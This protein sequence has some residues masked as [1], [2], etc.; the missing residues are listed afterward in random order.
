MLH[1]GGIAV[2]GEPSDPT[3]LARAEQAYFYGEDDAAV[4][5]PQ[6]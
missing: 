1:E 3:F 5:V 6:G 4:P 2:R